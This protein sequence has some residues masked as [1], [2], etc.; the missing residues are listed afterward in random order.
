MTP[1]DP[2]VRP[3]VSVENRDGSSA[4]VNTSKIRMTGT[5]LKRQLRQAYLSNNR[6]MPKI[7]IYNDEQALDNFV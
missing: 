5:N 3:T 1:T 2:P 4:A 6:T 7:V